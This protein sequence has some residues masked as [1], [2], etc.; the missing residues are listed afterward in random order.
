MV[1][2]IIVD[3]LEG[4]YLQ[5]KIND[6]YPEFINRIKIYSR[7]LSLNKLVRLYQ[8]SDVIVTLSMGEA[9]GLPLLEAAATGALII[10]PREPNHPF[11]TEYNS[12]LYESEPIKT[13]PTG[14][15]VWGSTESLGLVMQNIALNSTQYNQQRL[16]MARQVPR[17]FSWSIA[18]DLAWSRLI[19]IFAENNFY[20]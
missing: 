14:G 6:E 5:K 12:V 18:A 19:E 3:W 7:P 11:L 2:L 10:A 9:W 1:R 20:E 13:G 4:D 15:R 8:R 16:E 17:R